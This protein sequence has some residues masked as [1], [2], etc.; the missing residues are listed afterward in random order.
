MSVSTSPG[1]GGST[2][3]LDLFKLARTVNLLLPLL[4]VLAAWAGT[5]LSFYYHFLTVPL[6]LLNLLNLSCLYVQRRHTLLRNFG[7]VAQLRYFLE[8]IGPEMRQYL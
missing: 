1:I 6:L 5:S 2:A 4:A 7:I 3:A 8:S